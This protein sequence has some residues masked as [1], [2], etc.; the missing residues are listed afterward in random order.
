MKN[1]AK[2][3]QFNTITKPRRNAEKAQ[4]AQYMDSKKSMKQQT[5]KLAKKLK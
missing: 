2:Q 5:D 3:K 1:I 4:L